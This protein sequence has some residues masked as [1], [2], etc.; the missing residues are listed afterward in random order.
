MAYGRLDPEHLLTSAPPVAWATDGPP[1]V[2]QDGQLWGVFGTSGA[3]KQAQINFQVA[4]ASYWHGNH[5]HGKQMSLAGERFRFGVVGSGWRA[6]F[7]MRVAAALPERFHVS[8]VVTRTPERAEEVRTGWGVSA[9]SRLED[10]LKADRP[11]FFVLSV[12]RSVVVDWVERLV[13]AGAPVLCETPPAQDLNGLRRV[14][15]LAAR[16]GRV[17]VAEQYQYQPLHAA[18]LALTDG[19]AIG[20]VVMAS[21]S[22]CH[23]YHAFSLIRRHLQVTGEGAVLRAATV[24]SEVE[25]GLSKSGQRRASG[26]AEEVRTTGLVE[27]GRSLGVYDFAS[28]QYFSYVRS[29]HVTIRGSEGEIAD[30]SVR[31]LPGLDDPVT[32]DLR[33]EHAGHEGNLGGFYLRGLSMG[34]RWVYRNP[35]PGARLSDDEVAVATCMELM[36]RHA[37]GGPPFYGL[38]DAAQ[39]HY[40]SL[41]LHRAAETGE[42]VHATPQPWAAAL[43]DPGSVGGVLPLPVVDDRGTT[44]AGL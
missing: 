27:F 4:P 5:G 35:F 39:D 6:L 2:L 32:Q 29:P 31:R 34:D 1:V 20:N 8:G 13:A 22:V 43:L 16:Q 11:D 40:L 41:C 10:L 33:R 21:L 37:G 38:A 3:D 25:S 28:E 9:Y 36:G 42:A 23:D 19:G 26:T 14:T 24:R 30:Y 44:G 17:Q 18:R 12:P 7:F 15:E